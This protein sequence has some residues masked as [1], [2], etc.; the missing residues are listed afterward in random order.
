M[1]K[2]K[3][4]C[5]ELCGCGIE[6]DECKNAESENNDPFLTDD[7]DDGDINISIIEYGGIGILTP[8]GHIKQ[9]QATS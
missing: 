7:E 1:P 8:L 4:K 3:L 6:S 2:N 5:T 9:G